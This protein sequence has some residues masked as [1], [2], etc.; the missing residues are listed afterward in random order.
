MS[1]AQRR[2]TRRYRERRNNSG[3]K[4]IEVQVPV[5]EAA[6]IKKAA[7]VL[8]E[9]SEK[10]ARLR[11][12]LGFAPGSDHAASALAAFAMSEPLSD[13]AETLWNKAM[14]QVARDRKEPALNRPRKVML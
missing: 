1:T 4:R 3:F 6:V 10:A 14:E 2:A 7:A 9:R 11:K 12:H 13:E 5:D 8:C